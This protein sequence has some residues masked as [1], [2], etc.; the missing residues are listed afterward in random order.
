MC[1][2]ERVYQ[3]SVAFSADALVDGVTDQDIEFV[4][5]EWRQQ[6]L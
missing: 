1:S 6:V 2:Q 3:L 5:L 4:L